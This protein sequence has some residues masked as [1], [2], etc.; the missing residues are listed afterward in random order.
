MLQSGEE[1]SPIVMKKVV[2]MWVCE[3]RAGGKPRNRADDGR[4]FGCAL[5]VF[6]N[7]DRLCWLLFTSCSWTEVSYIR[8]TFCLSKKW[9][10]HRGI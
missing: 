10:T 6:V 3:M 1:Q 2:Q 7:G 8:R 9:E 4:N 5:A